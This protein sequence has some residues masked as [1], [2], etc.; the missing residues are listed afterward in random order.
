MRPQRGAPKG[1]STAVEH[2]R[3]VNQVRTM[4]ATRNTRE[5]I[6]QFGTH[7]WGISR[8]AIDGYIQAATAE[9]TKA[10]AASIDQ[11]SALVREIYALA[12][13]ELIVAEDWRGVGQLLS[14]F[15]RLLGLDAPLRVEQSGALRVIV[16]YVDADD[17]PAPK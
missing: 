9:L 14:Q 2:R 3:R 17:Q 13:R 7:A 10:S 1:K 8:R 4:L 6:I 12:I 5:D 11:D 15:S 16:E